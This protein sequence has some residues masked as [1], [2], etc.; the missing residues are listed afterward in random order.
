MAF[1]GSSYR[2]YYVA[3]NYTSGLTDVTVS[4]KK[5]DGTSLGP[6]AMIELDTSG[7]YYYDYVL[8]NGGEYIFTADSTSVPSKFSKSVEANINVPQLPYAKFD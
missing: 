2:V 1:I 5:P 6:Y 8:V 7:I 3:L 4:I